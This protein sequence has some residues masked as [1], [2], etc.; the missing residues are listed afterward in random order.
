MNVYKQLSIKEYNDK[1]R[2]EDFKPNKR[3]LKR[4]LHK[5]SRH[6]M[7]KIKSVCINWFFLLCKTI[8]KLL[9]KQAAGVG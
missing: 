9:C 3:Y 7:K 2:W 6:K 1:Y 5:I 8:V 4:R